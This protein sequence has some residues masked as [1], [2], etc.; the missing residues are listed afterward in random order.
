MPK[1]YNKKAVER[2]RRKMRENSNASPPNRKKQP[3]SDLERMV[4]DMLD[5]LK[6]EWEREKP[7]QY[8]RGH[9]RYYDFHL[10][11]HGVLIEVDGSYWH[12]SRDKPSYV[13]MM[14]K[15]NDM[16]KN[17]LAKKEGY[18]LI[19]IKEEELIGEYD[20]IKENLSQRVGKE[21]L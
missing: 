15:K 6:I 13:I 21:N 12:D 20:T 11:E 14:A 9:W 5:D 1:R 19:R 8:M 17:W 10:I 7:L 3:M 4:A 2:M 18:E 16:I